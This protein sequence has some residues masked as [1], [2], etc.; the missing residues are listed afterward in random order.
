MVIKSGA[1]VLHSVV[2]AILTSGYESIGVEE[3]RSEI[4]NGLMRSIVVA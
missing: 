1:K 4:N 3:F 2:D